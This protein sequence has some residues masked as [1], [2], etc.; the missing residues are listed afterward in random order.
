MS[1]SLRDSVKS[2]VIWRSGS[3]IL[4]QLVAWGSTLAVIRILDPADYG[5][6]AMTQV[7][8]AFLSF[9]GGYGFASSLIQDRE[10]DAKKIRQAFGLL[11]LVNGM[12]ALV[13]LGLAPFAAD[14]YRAPVVTDLLMMQA[15]IYLATPFI[16]LPEVLLTREMD[17]KR[18]AIANL[19]A[20]FV[21]ASVALFCAL[22]DYGVWTLVFA[23]LSAFWTRALVLMIAARFTYLPSFDFKGAGPMFNFGLA[24]LAS[25]LFWTIVTQADVFIGARF[26][27][28]TELGLYAE[29]LFLTFIIATKFVPPLNEVAFPAY[30]RLQDDPATLRFAFLKAV[31]LIMLV[32]CPLYFGLAMVA[33]EAVGFLLGEKWLPM[34]PIVTVLGFAMPALT[35]HTLFAPAINAIGMPRITMQASLFGAC[36]MPFAFY[37]GMQWGAIG[38]AWVWVIGFPL[39]PLFTFMRAKKHLGIEASRMIASLAPGIG[40]S[41]AMAVIVYALGTALP[42]LG[43]FERLVLLVSAGGLSY[44]ALLFLFSRDT[45]FELIRLVVKRQAPTVQAAG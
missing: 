8:M 15:L 34:A 40:A 4:A 42:A 13:Q 31:R 6:F 44:A 22:S 26:L 36:F 43:N 39:I 29:A 21:S 23:P 11:L 7:I 17:F 41:A 32:T 38:L 45:L 37:F 5:I 25:H 14:Y 18:P 1:S 2:A 30:A 24:L 28:P 12:I 9:L 33:P 10:I 35:L 27:S 3:Q 19:T 20:T 16:A